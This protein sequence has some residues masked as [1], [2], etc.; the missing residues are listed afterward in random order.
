MMRLAPVAVAVVW[1]CGCSAFAAI[2]EIE[3]TGQV[4]YNQIRSAPLSAIEAGDTARLVFVVDSQVFIDSP[5]VP[6]RGYVVEFSTISLNIGSTQVALRDPLPAGRTRYFIIRN[7]DPGVDG[8]FLNSGIG[9]EVPNP[10]PLAANGAVGEFGNS[11]GVTYE[12]D[13]LPSLAIADAVGDYDFQGLQVYNWTIDDGPFNPLSIEFATLAIRPRA[14]MP[15]ADFNSDGVI[16]AADYT[17][18]RDLRGAVGN[19]LA[20]DANSDGVVDEL[21]YAIW[22]EQFGESAGSLASNSMTVPE[23]TAATILAL[24]AL[25]VAAKRNGRT[26]L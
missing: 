1:A 24:V 25:S 15:Q 17:V 5:N 2:F 22:R 9:V 21:D 7:N 26:T 12:T 13:R 19:D 20:A 11:F 6:T 3:V 10:W 16:D 23:P 18:W 14:A 8:F 4:E